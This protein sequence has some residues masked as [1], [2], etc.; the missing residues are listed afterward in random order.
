[1][2]VV[3]GPMNLEIGERFTLADGR[4]AIKFLT[5]RYFL[6]NFHPAPL[7]MANQWGEYE[8]SS[9]E[10][11]YQ[12]AKAC[13]S[14]I[15]NLST[16]SDMRTPL[17]KRKGLAATSGIMSWKIGKRPKGRLWRMSCGKN[18]VIIRQCGAYW[19]SR[20]PQSWSRQ[21]P[22]IC[23]GAQDWGWQIRWSWTQQ[24]GEGRM[25]WATCWWICEKFWCMSVGLIML[26]LNKNKINNFK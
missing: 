1:M 14:M 8:F 6:S 20:L 11:G 19:S 3:F 23:F 13:F 21:M 26:K 5:A 16:A 15:D 25:F 2:A 9:S 24:I 18:S 4:A 12:A 17:Q 7:V 22:M 10:H